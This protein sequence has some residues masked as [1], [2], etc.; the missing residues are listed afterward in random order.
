MTPPLAQSGNHADALREAYFRHAR[1]F[2]HANE[3]RDEVWRAA[4]ACLHQRGFDLRKIEHIPVGF[5]PAAE[6]IWNLLLRDGFAADEVRASNL[7]ADTRLPGRLMGPIRDREKRIIS[8]WAK[9][10]QHLERTLFLSTHWKEE[11]AIFGLDVAYPAVLAG[12]Q[13]LLVVEDILDAMY[14][15]SHGLPNVAAIGNHPAEMTTT[16]WE[17]LDDLGIHR[18]TLLVDSFHESHEAALATIQ[19]AAQACRAPSVYVLPPSVHRAAWFSD[20]PSRTAN[21]EALQ[22]AL[23]SHRIHGFHYLAL[24]MVAL[25]KNDAPWTDAGRRAVLAEA[26]TFYA[27]AH[28]RN[29][30]QL[31]AF[32]LQPLLEALGL[33]HDARHSWHDAWLEDAPSSNGSHA[34]QK[35]KASDADID[36]RGKLP[37]SAE[38]MDEDYRV[39]EVPE[40]PRALRAVPLI[41]PPTEDA[42]LHLRKPVS[43]GY[44]EFHQ[45]ERI[46]CLCWD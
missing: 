43:D 46:V 11:A 38:A 27:S 1:E 2:L 42:S 37:A 6:P 19:R 39:I 5:F 25:H 20:K 36:K 41:A 31:E 14:L 8:F 32:F 29:V 17:R 30:P 13:D 7:L 24:S 4:R 18:V 15:H 44:C 45:C 10:P 3:G 12:H 23:A 22:T 34:T 21:V 33:G 9:L 28:Q 40:P 26:R 16:R 35:D